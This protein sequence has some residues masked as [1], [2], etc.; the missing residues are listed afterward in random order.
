MFFYCFSYFYFPLLKGV[1]T[2][3]LEQLEGVNLIGW[4][5]FYYLVCLVAL[6]VFIWFGMRRPYQSE[7]APNVRFKGAACEFE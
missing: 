5:V 7:D 3:K 6:F 1:N 2:K 4:F